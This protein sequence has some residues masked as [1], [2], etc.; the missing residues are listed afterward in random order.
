MYKPLIKLFIKVLLLNI[1]NTFLLQGNFYGLFK[2]PLTHL[3][4]GIILS[5]Q[6][7]FAAL[8]KREKNLYDSHSQRVVSSIRA[9]V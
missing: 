3:W 2:Q 5:F 9:S 8:E 7:F 6:Y 4:F 1:S